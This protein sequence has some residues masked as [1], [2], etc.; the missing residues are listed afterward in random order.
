MRCLLTT[1]LTSAADLHT[2]QAAVPVPSNISLILQQLFSLSKATITF[3]I[4]SHSFS[5]RSRGIYPNS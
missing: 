4:H 1:R 2:M 5:L 3:S